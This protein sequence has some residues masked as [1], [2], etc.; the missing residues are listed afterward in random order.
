MSSALFYPYSSISHY[1]SLLPCHFSSFLSISASFSHKSTSSIFFVCCFLFL[2]LPL[3]LPFSFLHLFFV[4]SS[5]S[6]TPLLPLLHLFSISSL[7]SLT[8]LLQLNIIHPIK[9]ATLSPLLRFFPFSSVQSLH[10]L[11]FPSSLCLYTV[12]LRL[13][14][15]KKIHIG[16][17]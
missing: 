11:P 14:S 5:S 2:H 9:K 12:N 16:H 4:S 10:L 3:S 7:S 6:F 1:I 17:L 13:V 8:V 15:I